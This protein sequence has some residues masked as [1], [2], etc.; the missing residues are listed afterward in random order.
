MKKNT[1][2]RGAQGAHIVQSYLNYARAC[3]CL[4]SQSRDRCQPGLQRHRELDL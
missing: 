1:S 2:Q 4:Q 3:R